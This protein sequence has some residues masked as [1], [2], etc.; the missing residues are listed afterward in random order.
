[1]Y[2]LLCFLISMSE[3]ELEMVSDPAPDTPVT[4][5]D[6]DRKG[7]ISIIKKEVVNAPDDA[8]ISVIIIMREI[9]LICLV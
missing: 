4:E 8:G 3:P 2:F 7:E 5:M 6:S 9:L 1:M